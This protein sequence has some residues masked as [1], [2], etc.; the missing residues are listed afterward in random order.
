MNFQWIS[1]RSGGENGRSLEYTSIEFG[2]HSDSVFKQTNI[3]DTHSV[4][5]HKSI[6]QTL[7]KS[8][9]LNKFVYFG[10]ILVN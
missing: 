8:F 1:I 2:R 3:F 7:R 9:T 5:N 6:E 4:C 10:I